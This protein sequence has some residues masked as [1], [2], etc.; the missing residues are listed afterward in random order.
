MITLHGRFK[1][2]IITEDDGKQT[3]CFPYGID[4]D[5]IDGRT[6]YFQCKSSNTEKPWWIIINWVFTDNAD[7]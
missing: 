5:K 1:H 3:P 6:G 7:K 2:S 4:Y